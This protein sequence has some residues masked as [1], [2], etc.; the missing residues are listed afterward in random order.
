MSSLRR[1]SSSV[2]LCR[3]RKARQRMGFSSKPVGGTVSGTATARGSSGGRGGHSTGNTWGDVLMH[4]VS[5]PSGSSSLSSSSSRNSR[6]NRSYPAISNG[7]SSRNSH[8]GNYQHTSN[9]NGVVSSVGG[10]GARSD[11]SLLGRGLSSSNTDAREQQHW[12]AGEASSL[13]GMYLPPRAAARASRSPTANGS[14][15]GYGAPVAP[16]GDQRRAL[17]HSGRRSLSGECC[18]RGE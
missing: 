2:L 15:D 8:R 18:Q 12:R 1:L 9:S 4:V 16:E 5:L 17:G 3:H 14:A 10:L 6:N 13:G 7:S 11:G